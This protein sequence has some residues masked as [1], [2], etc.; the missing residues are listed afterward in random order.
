MSRPGFCTWEKN[1]VYTTGGRGDSRAHCF[2]S[3]YPFQNFPGTIFCGCIRSG[4]MFWRLNMPESKRHVL[5]RGRLRLSSS[6]A[7][8]GAASWRRRSPYREKRGRQISAAE[9]CGQKLLAAVPGDFGLERTGLHA[10][11]Q[12]SLYWKIFQ[13]H[14]QLVC[15]DRLSEMG[16]VELHGSGDDSF[17]FDREGGKSMGRCFHHS[18]FILRLR[19]PRCFRIPCRRRRDWFWELW[20]QGM[21]VP[22]G[23]KRRNRRRH[24]RGRRRHAVR[25]WA[26][27]LPGIRT[28]RPGTAP[29]MVPD[30][31]VRAGSWR[32]GTEQSW[33]NRRITREKNRQILE[34]M[35]WQT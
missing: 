14:S 15:G 9:R 8:R 6:H 13:S 27:G 22:M 31:T 23:R 3:H 16:N 1:Q 17:G 32:A 12:G 5:R 21:A 33:R 24:R 11:G 28:K 10:N 7:G 26:V 4:A 30:L 34:D 20:R 35:R 2:C 19:R 18:G 25:I 29:V